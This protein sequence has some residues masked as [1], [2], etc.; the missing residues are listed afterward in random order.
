MIETTRLRCHQIRRLAQ[1]QQEV[2]GEPLLRDRNP[3]ELEASTHRFSYGL[4]RD[5]RAYTPGHGV[6]RAWGLIILHQ[7]ERHIVSS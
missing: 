2:E 7:E 6:L 4:P 3:K 1:A 5:Y